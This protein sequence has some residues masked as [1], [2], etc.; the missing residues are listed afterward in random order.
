ML[1]KLCFQALPTRLAQSVATAALFVFS[2]VLVFGQA[3]TGSISGLVTDPS[4]AP[5]PEVAITV[6]D[7]NR[8]VAVTA[9][10]NQDGFYSVSQLAPGTY[11]VRAEKAG[12]RPYVLDTLPIS[13]Q[14][15]AGI[16][17]KLQVGAVSESVNVTA[18]AQALQTNTSE[19]GTVTTNQQIAN[20][21]LNGRNVQSLVLLT[22]GVTGMNANGGTGE[23]FE[24][25]GRFVVNGGRDSSSAIQLDGVSVDMPSY[26]PG[27]NF[28]SAVPS[29]EGIQEFRVQT[30]AFSA[31]Y[32][33]TGG[34]VVTMVTKSG[35]NAV[36]GSAY[37]FLRNSAL[38]ANSFFNNARRVERGSFKRNEFGATLGAPVFLPKIYDGRNRTF[39]FTEYQ[40]RRQSSATT[41][42]AT[43]PTDLERLGDFSQTRNA[44]GQVITI[45]NPFSTREDPARPGQFIRDPFPGNRIPSNLLS[46]VALNLQKTYPQ[47]NRPGQLFTNQQN[48]VEIGALRDTLNRGSMKF[49]HMINDRQRFFVRY[50]ILNWDNAQPQMWGQNN[51]GCPDPYCVSFYQRQ[52]N[53]VVDYTNSLTPTTILNVSYGFARGILDRGSQYQGFRPSSLGLPASIEEGADMLLFPQV[54]IPNM[55]VPGVQTH[56]NFR[57]AN[58][59]H[60]VQGNITRVAGKHT[61]KVGAETRVFL[62]N[63]MQA[64]YS[65]I[66]N[67]STA[68]TQGPDPR[69]ASTGAGLGYASFLLGFGSDGSI[70][71][72]VRPAMASNY[73]G[74]Y[75]QDDF[76]VNRK[77]TVNLG[78]R[79][80]I[81]GGT[82]ERYGRLSV[83]NPNVRSPLSDRVGLDLRGGYEFPDS[84]HGFAFGNI[85]PRIG[86]AYQI[87]PE[88][89]IRSGYGIFFGVPPYAGVFTGPM[90]TATTPW[91]PSI[92]GVTP[93]F[94]LDNPYPQGYNQYEGSANGLLAAM[95][96]G[97]SAPIP[98]EMRAPYNQQWNFAVQHTLLQNLLVEAAYAGNKGTHLPL[99]WQ[100]NQLDPSLLGPE[101][102]RT[103]PNP[104]FGVVPIGTLAQPTVQAGQLRRPFPQYPGV[105]SASASVGNSNYHSLQMK[106][107]KRFARGANAMVAYT[108]SK[109]IDD[110]GTN[111]WNSAANFRNAYCRACDRGLS[112]YDMPHRIV[113]N[114]TYEL[115]FGR[116]KSFGAN[117][118]PVVDAVLGQWQMNGILTYNSSRPLVFNV[119]QNTSNSF[120]GGQHPD[121]TGV[122]AELDG[123]Q[124]TLD[125]WF[126]TSQFSLPAPYTFGNLGRTTNLRS[127]PYKNI[128]FSVFKSFR[129]TEGTQVQFRT[130]AFNLLNQVVFGIPDTTVGS[131][132]FGRV[133]GTGNSPR[134]VQFALKILF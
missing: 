57:T 75:L 101:M 96:S 44:Q 6:T 113:A 70:T 31:E 59:V 91:V 89:V 73:V 38:D 128:D 64:T 84:I 20:L 50:V 14:Q 116:G 66:F 90:Y 54:G 10:T 35:T 78:L 16:D 49:D 112:I 17:I 79:W 3:F 4:G 71:K 126:D 88:T 124:R 53:G 95:S 83:F 61:L 37:E 74:L 102:T 130:E 76:K 82:R 27:F 26:I 19:L 18:D 85:G 98:A 67:F 7:I 105:T 13:A 65:P 121:T 133:T 107:E 104:F 118:H 120:G 117:W 42:V 15:K 134:Q 129:I 22:P 60:S 40:G 115:P 94:T 9:T 72:G 100:Y 62:V 56:W 131:Q 77:L 28:Y 119:V 39:F 2:G 97:V 125:R 123:D 11:R 29:A 69:V 43:V 41:N 1:E 103:V 127:D 63:Q 122:S 47:A 86:L 55:S 34:G 51:P 24:S 108:F 5:T 81:E 8:N 45:Y 36:H 32:G 87:T 25:Q 93:T 21:P 80:D 58:M 68:G 106:I 33:R 92:N 110:G 132:N 109:L 99:S 23:S 52:Q 12:F 30:N 111:A 46:T 114:F 48:Y